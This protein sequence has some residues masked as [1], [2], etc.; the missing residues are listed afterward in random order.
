VDP[1]NA[2]Q[3]D[4]ANVTALGPLTTTIPEPPAGKG[5]NGV[6]YKYLTPP[7]PPPVFAVP[8]VPDKAYGG[9]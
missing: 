1:V 7:A 8:L 5:L 2:Q 6:G 4:P 3:G 9:W